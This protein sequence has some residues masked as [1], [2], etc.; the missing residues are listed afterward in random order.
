MSVGGGT[1]VDE[2]DVEGAGVGVV[3]G[4]G[5]GRGTVVTGAVAGPVAGAA[6]GGG[7]ASGRGEMLAE[8]FITRGSSGVIGAG[9][10]GFEPGD[11]VD[12]PSCGPGSVSCC[13]CFVRQHP[14]VAASVRPTK[15]CVILMRLR[16]ANLVPSRRRALTLG[17]SDET[18][19]SHQCR[20]ATQ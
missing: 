14:A 18:L 12:S 20:P 13:G 19:D 11:A 5:T 1:G 2:V 15:K 6:D 4:A 8:T 3:V 16:G 9:L 7:A 10:L 17:E